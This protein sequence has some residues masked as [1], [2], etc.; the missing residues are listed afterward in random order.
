MPVHDLGV[1]VLP[2]RRP[3][4]GDFLEPVAVKLGCQ[5]YALV[6]RRDDYI[7]A[8]RNWVAEILARLH[9]A[10]EN[11]IILLVYPVSVGDPDVFRLDNAEAIEN[12][13]LLFDPFSIW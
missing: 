7:C 4:P 3:P 5:A 1:D 6:K 2:R 8:A 13:A 12:A 11:Y 10:H 9:P